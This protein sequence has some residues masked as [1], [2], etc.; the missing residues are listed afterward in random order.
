V[1]K[2]I[3]AQQ[4]GAAVAVMTNNAAGLPPVEGPI[5]SN[6]DTGAP[7]TVTIPFAGVAG[8]QASPTSD[9]GKLQA[10]P[11]GTT[12]AL[13]VQNFPNPRIWPSRRSLP[14]VRGPVTA[15]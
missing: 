12:A 5:T 3:F 6:P 15:A 11:V 7:F 4:A 1:A 2:A 14:A 10:S 9:S 13:S 8:N